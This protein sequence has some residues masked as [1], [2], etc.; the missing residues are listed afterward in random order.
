MPTPTSMVLFDH[1]HNGHRPIQKRLPIFQRADHTPIMRLTERDKHILEAVH[2]YDGMLADYQIHALFFTGKSQMQVRTKLLYQHGYLSR[3]DRRKRAMLPYMLYWLGVQ[4]AAY[5]AGLDGQSVNEFG[6]RREPKWQQ[7]EHDLT[8]NDVRIAVVHACRTSKLLALE[9]WIPQ[10][11]FWAHPDGVE[12]TDSTGKMLKR[13]VR[14]DGYCVILLGGKRFR[15][16]W[17]IDRRTEDNPR[18][19]REKVYP[20]IAYIRSEA[21]RQR[22]GYNAGKI[23]IVTTGERRLNN[24][25]RQAEQ[26]VGKDAR[27]FYFTTL[28]QLTSQ[29]VLTAPIWQRGGEPNTM[30]LFTL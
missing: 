18:F 25:K 10:S 4:G 12:Y 3:P 11:E 9:E 26:A 22:F 2:A 28:E 5:V 27:L 21:Y 20:G 7:V 30:P 23:L 24:M 13:K 29:T 15:L 17:E 1:S 16:L 19:V 6:Y 14:P 8:V